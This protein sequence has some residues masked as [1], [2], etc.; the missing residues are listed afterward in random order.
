MKSKEIQNKIKQ[1]NLDKYGKEYYFQTNDKKQ[2]SKETCIE[3]YGEEY[4]VQTQDFKNKSTKTW[5]QNYGVKHASQN[6][7]VFNKGLKTRLLIHKYKDTNLTYQGS[8]EFD[9]INIFHDKIHIINAPS[10]KY[11]FEGKNRVYHPD[12][13]IPSLNLIIEIKNK[14]LYK[15][16]FE[17]I[18]A[19][20]KATIAA[21]YNYLMILDKDYNEFNKIIK[22]IND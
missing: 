19:K 6:I 8:Y 13:F 3:K 11:I 4:Y 1:T 14:Y 12:F 20:E 15:Q 16:N 9:F 21:G 5:L 17:E 10:I 7:E 18:R 2:K 22:P